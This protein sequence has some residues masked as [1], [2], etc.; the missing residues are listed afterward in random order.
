MIMQYCNGGTMNRLL[1]VCSQQ[2]AERSPLFVWRVFAQ[3]LD[4]FFDLHSVDP[5]TVH[6]DAHLNNL[7]L[8]FADEHARLPD[9]YLG[10]FG[11]AKLV[12]ARVLEDAPDAQGRR[13]LRNMHSLTAEADREKL[14]KW[15]FRMSED[16]DQ[17][18]FCMS[19]L[20]TGAS[21]DSNCYEVRESMN[22]FVPNPA[23][24]P[25]E[26]IDCYFALAQIVA[27]LDQ[28]TWVDWEPL[29]RR[30]QGLYMQ[31][32]QAEPVPRQDLRWTRPDRY[33]S[34]P[35]DDPVETPQSEDV[36]L[37]QTRVELLTQAQEVP[38]PWRIA[39]V[40]PRTMEVLGVEN[41]EMNLHVPGPD[42]PAHW[43][44]PHLLVPNQAYAPGGLALPAIL[45]AA[46]NADMCD[47]FNT[48]HSA[49]YFELD[50]HLYM[51]L[52]MARAS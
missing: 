49:P 30:V 39:R 10:D 24:F 34:D 35:D 36:A 38:G 16:L 17:V 3:L 33:Q 50:A 15:I 8:H 26:L 14:D 12:A 4:M 48:P 31:A 22:D 20:L 47:R 21:A 5:P 13:P 42:H 32:E 1:Q 44:L 27:R 25:A 37:F 23:P 52:Y 43:S 28:G 45:A 6:G 29:M 40:D 41:L 19:Y 11:K 9:V 7:F 2:Q 46:R 18:L 51:A